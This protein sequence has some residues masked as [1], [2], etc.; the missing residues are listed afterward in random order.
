MRFQIKIVDYPEL[1]DEEKKLDKSLYKDKK[2]YTLILQQ[3]TPFIEILDMFDFS[4]IDG[5]FI[6]IDIDNLHAVYILNGKKSIRYSDTIKNALET[7]K[8]GEE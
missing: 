2:L 3:D 6:N 1:T 5:P 7:L 8:E 4:D